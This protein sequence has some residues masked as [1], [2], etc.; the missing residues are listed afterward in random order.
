MGLVS[1][2][3]FDERDCLSFPPCFIEYI[4]LH[5]DTGLTPTFQHQALCHDVLMQSLAAVHSTSFKSKSI[6]S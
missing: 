6:P 5:K 1:K 2:P 3:A 4:L